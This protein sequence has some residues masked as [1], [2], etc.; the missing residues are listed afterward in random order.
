M[1]RG[2]LLA[3]SLPGL[4]LTGTVPRQL[5]GT[6]AFRLA[7][8]KPADAPWLKTLIGSGVDYWPDEAVTGS[9]RVGF[10]P[11]GPALASLTLAA[12]SVEMSASP[13]SGGFGPDQPMRVT[14][15]GRLRDFIR[16]PGLLPSAALGN[17]RAE[18]SFVLRPAR[19]GFAFEDVRAEVGALKLVGAFSGRSAS[20]LAGTLTVRAARAG[21]AAAL[22]PSVLG[23]LPP[24]M[25]GHALVMPVEF[26][27]S[28]RG[29]A[30]RV[31][32]ARLG[33]LTLSSDVGLAG[34][35]D[36]TAKVAITG[37]IAATFLADTPPWL[38]ELLGAR[39]TLAADLVVNPR[40]AVEAR[41]LALDSGRV[42]MRGRLDLPMRG[43]SFDWAA[44]RGQL[45]GE[46]DAFRW[47]ALDLPK[48]RYELVLKGADAGE[49]VTGT[50]VYPSLYGGTV[51]LRLALAGTSASDGRV[52]L[53]VAN[54]NLAD[55]CRHAGFRLF[56][57]G[58]LDAEL[59][60][61]APASLFARA[62]E[63]GSLVEALMR[64]AAANGRIAIRDGALNDV[65]LTQRTAGGDADGGVA[66][67][68]RT[69]FDELS[70]SILLR[71]GMLQISDGRFRTT[72]YSLS[73]GGTTQLPRLAMDL[74][75]KGQV[76]VLSR[77]ST[78]KTLISAPI[79]PLAI[80]GTPDKPSYEFLPGQLPGTRAITNTVVEGARA[81]QRVD[82]SVTASQKKVDKLFSDKFFR[83][84]LGRR[85]PVADAA[86]ATAEA[87]ADAGAADAGARKAYPVCG[88]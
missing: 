54:M 2:G 55:A 50:I 74:L 12:S 80:R 58:R 52:E 49:R 25:L 45:A 5:R 32:G 26:R 68:A 16:D 62:G 73:V 57:M 60:G 83:P 3:V 59:R 19:S 82:A 10:T 84:L 38:R 86:S 23:M 21:E 67:G 20:D 63:S 61:G 69:P 37:P 6:G 14:L 24:D 75:V 77:V 27:G 48:G 35:G 15:A 28:P 51:N 41:S 13:L 85:K 33:P 11:R 53:S 17:Q 34:A 56:A 65:D 1:S 64:N 18:A 36:T 81:A 76:A 44:A 66:A 71:D 78:G 22:F 46:I 40:R 4:Q 7:F 31:A 9:A 88:P 29:L 87:P 47:K 79:L 70:G 39:Q 43:G 72:G 42:R 30:L 8:G